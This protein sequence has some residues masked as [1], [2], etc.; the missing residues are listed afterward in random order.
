MAKAAE[1]H[2]DV[3]AE[4]A[5]FRNYHEAK[6]SVMADW[7]AAWRTWVGNARPGV[8]SVAAAGPKRDSDEYAALHKSASWWR[9]AGFPTIWDAMASKC[10][11]DNAHEFRD[12]QR[13]GVAA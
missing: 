13:V 1:K 9:E 11:H 12:G 5:K 4:L 7:Q 3:Q 6:G 10:W 8:A 2:L